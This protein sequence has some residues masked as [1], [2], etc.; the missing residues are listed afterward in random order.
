M[1]APACCALLS[2]LSLNCA[3]A[4]QSTAFT[5]Q[6]RLTNGGNPANGP[7]DMLFSL[8]DAQTGGTQV[9]SSLCFDNVQVAAGLF[10]LQ[11]DFGQQFASPMPRFLEVFVRADSGQD[12]TNQSNFFVLSPRQ[13]LTATPLANHAKSAFAL[14]APDG[15]PLNALFVTNDGKIGIGTTSPGHSVTIANPAPTLALHDTDSTTDQAGYISYRDGLNVEKAWV[16]Y[17]SPGS[18]D[19]TILNARPGGDIVLTPLSGD[20]V[21]LV[22]NGGNVGV[23]TNAPA[24]K[25]DVRGNIHLG[26]SGQ[27]R[28]TAS[29]ENLRIVRGNVAASG[30][31][32]VG[33]GFT[34]NHVSTGRY[35]ITFSPQFQNIPSVTCSAEASSAADHARHWFLLNPQSTVSILTYDDGLPADGAFS[36]IAVGGR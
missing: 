5:Y 12:C 29:E 25:L 28:A 16:G 35:V 2:L 32:T 7:H 18:P 9:G 31:V 17:G 24:A 23:G 33:S 22:G 14:D 21:V 10:M 11:L 26:S 13:A 15:A 36:F 3:A 4:A 6:G 27:L 20:N 19:F 8:L 30:L 34:V 1:R